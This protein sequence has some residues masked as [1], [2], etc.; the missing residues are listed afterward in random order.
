[1]LKYGMHGRCHLACS[2]FSLYGS[3]GFI[4]LF[5]EHHGVG[6]VSFH[7]LDLDPLGLM[8]WA[9]GSVAISCTVAI[10]Y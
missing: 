9:D 10:E 3:L 2:I 6:R 1:L 7:L 4:N 8:D 5:W